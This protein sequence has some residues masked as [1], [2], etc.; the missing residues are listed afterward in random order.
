MNT[1]LCFVQIKLL[2]SKAKIRLPDHTVCHRSGVAPTQDFITYKISTTYSMYVFLYTQ[3][4]VKHTIIFCIYAM[5]CFDAL[6]PTKRHLW[7]SWVIFI[8]IIL[9]SHLSIASPINISLQCLKIQYWV[10][11]LYK[12][13]NKIEV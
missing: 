11:Y 12:I 2:K 1:T 10:W 5:R 4:I 8:L 7:T 6:S 3:S 9:R 13:Y